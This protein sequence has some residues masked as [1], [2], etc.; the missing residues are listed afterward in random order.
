MVS[1]LL[2]RDALESGVE[3]LK[4]S[5]H[6]SFIVRFALSLHLLHHLIELGNLLLKI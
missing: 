3:I 4:G 2:I 1:P 6:G 5:C